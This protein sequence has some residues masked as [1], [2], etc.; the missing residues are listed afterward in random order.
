MGVGAGRADLVGGTAKA[1]LRE[2][3]AACRFR[4]RPAAEAHVQVDI[5]QIRARHPIQLFVH[6]S[7]ALWPAVL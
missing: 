2:N 3:I 5:G 4:L 7:L 6:A 1:G